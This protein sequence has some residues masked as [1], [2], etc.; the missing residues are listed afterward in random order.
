VTKAGDV[1]AEPKE[2]V[3]QEVK[4]EVKE[5]KEEP[6]EE[7]AAG[8]AAAP[9]EAPADEKEEASRVELLRCRRTLLQTPLS[10]PFPPRCKT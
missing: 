10:P 9:E 7:A 4:E 3:E 2:E 1:K 5:V 8:G 6:K